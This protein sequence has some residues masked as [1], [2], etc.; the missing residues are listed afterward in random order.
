MARHSA[1]RPR[2]GEHSRHIIPLEL[3]RAQGLQIYLGFKKE[4][5]C[6][7][8]WIFFEEPRAIASVR[9]FG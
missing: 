7:E 4:N 6:Q 8:G 1:K 9:K 3:S 5:D 2:G